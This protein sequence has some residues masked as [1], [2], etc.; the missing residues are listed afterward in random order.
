LQS[1]TT[2]SSADEFPLK[3]EKALDHHSLQVALAPHPL[4]MQRLKVG[5]VKVVFS[6][7]LIPVYSDFSFLSKARNR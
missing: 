6:L 7:M 3:S 2:R 1:N 4:R 5:K